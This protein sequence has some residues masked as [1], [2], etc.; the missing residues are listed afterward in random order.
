MFWLHLLL[1]FLKNN[2]KIFPSFSGKTLLI[3]YHFHWDLKIRRIQKLKISIIKSEKKKK[4]KAKLIAVEA[5]QSNNSTWVSV[6][7]S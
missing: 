4:H 6:P 1:I 3:T 7:Y 5:I 2:N